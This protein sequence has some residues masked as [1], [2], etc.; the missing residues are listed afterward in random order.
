MKKLRRYGYV[1]G[2]VLVLGTTPLA[3]ETLRDK[4][5]NEVVRPCVRD[6]ILAS[7]TWKGAADE[8]INE[9]I[10]IMM[11]VQKKPWK[12]AWKAAQPMLKKAGPEGHD[13]TLKYLRL[14]CKKRQLA[15]K[16]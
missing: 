15:E 14:V 3:A 16:Q 11:D 13:A 6:M 10:E 9:A 12:K 2:A 1:A 8:T 4:F 7:D 5:T